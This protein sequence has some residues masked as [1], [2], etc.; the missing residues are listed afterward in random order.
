MGAK[1]PHQLGGRETIAPYFIIHVIVAP[2][3]ILPHTKIRAP[4]D[5]LT[6]NKRQFLPQ[7]LPV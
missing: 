2:R 1:D 6:H 5:G 4:G 7:E 3:Y